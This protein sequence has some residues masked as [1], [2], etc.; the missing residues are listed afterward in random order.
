ML[1][2]PQA[3]YPRNLWKKTGAR[4]NKKN[5]GPDGQTMAYLDDA[6]ILAPPHRVMQLYHRL[7]AH[8]LRRAQL[9]LNP[10][11][12][13][14]W[15]S[16]A[17][18]ALLDSQSGP[19]AARLLTV[20]PVAPELALDSAVFRALFL[21]R[22]RLPLPLA[23]ARCRCGRPLDAPL[24]DHVAACRRSGVLRARGGPVE[25][26]AGRV[27]REAGAT[28]ATNILDRGL[29]LVAARHD[30]RRIEVIANGLPLWGGSQLAVDTTLISPLTSA[31]MP[32]RRRGRTAGVALAEARR[33]RERTYPEIAAAHRC[34]LV[35]L[36]LEVPK[37]PPS[38]VCSHVRGRAAPLRR[39]VLRVLQ[40]SSDDGLGLCPL[41]LPARSLPA[42]CPCPSP[43][44]RTLTVKRLS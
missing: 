9:R 30:E 34:R 12:T 44:Q 38:S 4:K 10:A 3:I 25:R 42:C 43:A 24:G 6:Y 36:G 23:P 32:R 33:A 8:A 5:L 35:V 26:A 22:S 7:E 31:G 20:R 2:Q 16:G 18:L 41:R 15:N 13:R 40:P 27:C 37:R 1:Q 17:E 14:A 21:R 28:V 11:K 19:F 39:N 29:N